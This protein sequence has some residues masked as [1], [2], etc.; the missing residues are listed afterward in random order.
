MSEQSPT[1]NSKDQE[2]KPPFEKGKDMTPQERENFEEDVAQ[3]DSDD[4]ST[5]TT[6]PP[7]D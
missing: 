5:P 3:G 2:P 7:P 6:P 4:D 1:A